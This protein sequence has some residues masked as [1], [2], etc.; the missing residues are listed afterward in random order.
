MTPSDTTF[1]I[2]CDW[3]YT[4]SLTTG[5]NGRHQSLLLM[6]L[7]KSVFDHNLFEI[8]DSFA[9]PKFGE[10]VKYVKLNSTTNSRNVSSSLV[11]RTSLLEV[12]C[13]ITV[14][15]TYWVDLYQG[16]VHGCYPGQPNCNEYQEE[17][18]CESISWTEYE[19]DEGGGGGTGGSGGSEGSEEVREKDG[20]RHNVQVYQFQEAQHMK[21]A[22]RVGI[23]TKVILQ[24][25]LQ[26]HALKLHP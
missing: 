12:V 24:A 25:L 6:A 4:D 3:Q 23:H 18:T 11:G 19:Y 16:Q 26:T 22:L 2:L 15:Y 21:I 10:S 5:L 20:Y 14:C 17:S 1:K 9:F 13:T 7:D 8:T